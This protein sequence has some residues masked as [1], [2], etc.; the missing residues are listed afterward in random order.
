MDIVEETGELKSKMNEVTHRKIMQLLVT[1]G[2]HDILA[3]SIS[4]WCEARC[5]NGLAIDSQLS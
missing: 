4:S 5:A 2:R 3:F 1:V